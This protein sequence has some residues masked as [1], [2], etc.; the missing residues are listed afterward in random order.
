MAKETEVKKVDEPIVE[1]QDLE[2]E[3][4]PDPKKPESR[5]QTRIRELV[6]EKKAANAARA[7]AELKLKDLESKQKASE[8]A[9]AEKL[10]KEEGTYKELIAKHTA[11]REKEK[12]LVVKKASDMVLVGMA[13][14][15]GILKPSYLDLFTEATLEVDADSLEVTNL[16]DV[17]KAFEKFKTENP[18]LFK[19]DGEPVK[20]TDNSSSKIIASKKEAKD[21]NPLELITR[22][23]EERSNRGKK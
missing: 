22:G 20:K 10:A 17:E 18:T 4:D 3:S 1:E 5:A 7:A 12:N 11:E 2:L 16:K 9:A 14:K 19:A 8:D 15:H 6:S 23:L 13:A 21:M